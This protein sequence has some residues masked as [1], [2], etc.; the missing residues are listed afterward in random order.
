MR[1]ASPLSGRG[2]VKM[3]EGK[4]Y[5]IEGLLFDG[6]MNTKKYRKLEKELKMIDNIT[7]DLIKHKQ[8]TK[9]KLLEM[10]SV[11]QNFAEKFRQLSGCNNSQKSGGTQQ[12]TLNNCCH[13][14]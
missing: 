10:S 1:R 12:P 13:R 14:T 4:V 6:K 2:K 7:D 5:G 9:E 11:L 3:L 8:I